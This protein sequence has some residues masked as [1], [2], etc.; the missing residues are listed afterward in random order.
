MGCL[1]LQ[2]HSRLAYKN[3][4]DAFLYIMPLSPYDMLRSGEVSIFRSETWGFW[5]PYSSGQ[6]TS[7]KN[8]P[9]PSAP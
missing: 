8:C 3:F 5:T 7:A 2:T 6:A 1:S 9:Y 4:H